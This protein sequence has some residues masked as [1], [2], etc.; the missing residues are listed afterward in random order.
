[1]S[2]RLLTIILILVVIG[3]FVGLKTTNQQNGGASVE[4]QL[5]EILQT[6][7][8]IEERLVAIESKQMGMASMIQGRMAGQVPTPPSRPMPP[9][10]DP[11]Q[12]YEI[13]VGHSS[14]KG[15]KDGKVTIVEFSDFQC[16][17]SGKFHPAVNQVLEVYSK[18]VKF[19]YK[20][21]PLTFH[22]QAEPAA[23]ASLA[24]REQGKYWEM[25]ELIFQNNQN[26]SEDT[27]KKLAGE[28]GLNIDKF[29][30]DY[31]DPK[32]KEYVQ[33]DMDVAQSANVRGTP[34]F[35]LNGKQTS[36]RD[37]NAWKAEIDAILSEGK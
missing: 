6:Q 35:Y 37:F 12:V 10:E 17:F 11:N 13:N 14:I 21:F 9:E 5:S 20:N 1:M 25:V 2:Q 4:Q 31:N 18:G 26:L 22:P 27:Y 30:T 8:S 28:L 36:A 19:I 16:P 33:Q 15:D 3:G 24:A 29:M 7:K 32:I 23:R 34:T